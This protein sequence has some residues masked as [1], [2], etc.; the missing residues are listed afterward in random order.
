MQ[1]TAC[2]DAINAS[3]QNHTRNLKKCRLVTFLA[4]ETM[5]QRDFSR[6]SRRADAGFNLFSAHRF[7]FAFKFEFEFEGHRQS[8][9]A[10][11]RWSVLFFSASRKLRIAIMSAC[12]ICLRRY[13]KTKNGES[14]GDVK[15]EPCPFKHS[16]NKSDA[17]AKEQ[18]ATR[19]VREGR[20]IKKSRAQSPR[21]SFPSQNANAKPK[22]FIYVS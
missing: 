15:Y 3:I 4:I 12:L 21:I 18:R 5:T 1:S 16:M 19:R 8:L 14:S 9:S 13:I 17:K 6:L 22:A 20:R 10:A 7:E 11:Q 2:R